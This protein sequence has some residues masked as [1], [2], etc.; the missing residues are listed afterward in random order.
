MTEEEI[1][2]YINPKTGRLKWKLQEFHTE[3][4]IESLDVK[5]NT[6]STP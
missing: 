1:N 4:G 2:L 6:T 5:Y 3:D